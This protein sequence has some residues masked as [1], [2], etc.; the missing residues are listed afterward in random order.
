MKEKTY[1]DYLAKQD[2]E[3]RESKAENTREDAAD[4]DDEPLGW[5]QL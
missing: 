2:G 1:R 5:V 3:E 4:Q